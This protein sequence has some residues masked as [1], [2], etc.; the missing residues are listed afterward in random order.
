MIMKN[1]IFL[2]LAILVLSFPSTPLMSAEQTYL[3]SKSDDGSVLIL[4]DGSVWAVSSLD[5]IDSAL[6]LPMSTII[7][8]D[9]EDS[10]I[11]ADDGEKIEARRIR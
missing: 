4:A 3:R 2:S 11:N 5:Q 1:L 9:S 6:W 8:S 7:I 10:L